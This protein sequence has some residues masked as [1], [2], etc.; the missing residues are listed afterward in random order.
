MYLEKIKLECR[1]SIEQCKFND[2]E[3]QK[4]LKKPIQR[5]RKVSTR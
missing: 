2:E 1:T 3:R 4:V 5:I